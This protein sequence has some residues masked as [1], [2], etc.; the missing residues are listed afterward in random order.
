MFHPQTNVAV[1]V[2]GCPLIEL[3]PHSRLIDANAVLKELD[4]MM[5]EGEV[6]TTAVNFAQTVINEAPTVIEA[7]GGV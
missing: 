5:V 7:E 3:K 4:E 1:R 2:S 6:F